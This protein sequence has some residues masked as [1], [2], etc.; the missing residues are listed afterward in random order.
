MQRTAD[1]HYQITDTLLPQSKPIFDNAT[2][3]DTAVDMFNPKTTLIQ[4]PVHA[5]LFQRQHLAS[6]FLH[7]H[8]DLHVR[9]RER[10]KAQILQQ[11]APGRQRIRCG[12]GNPLVVGAPANGFAEK[13]DGQ[14]RVDQKDILYRMILF[15]ATVT[16]RLFSSVLGADDAPLRPI[17]GKR[18]RSGPGAG[19]VDGGVIGGDASADMATAPVA[20][21]GTPSRC[22]SSVRQRVGASPRARSATSKAGSRTWIH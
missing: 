9:Q 6:W 18:G 14:R 7:R 1:F 12:I 19:A 3:L 5:L 15:L 11:S 22:A 4:G 16:L 8:Q 2:A 13:Q 21:S 17:M 20:V 10:D